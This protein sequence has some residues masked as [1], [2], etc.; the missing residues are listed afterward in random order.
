M[1]ITVNKSELLPIL[2]QCNSVAD[3]KSTMPILSNVLLHANGKLRCSATDLYQAVASD[4]AAKVK[5]K[6]TIALPARDLYERVKMLDGDI[7]ISTKGST[8]TIKSGSRVYKMHG[9]DGAEFPALPTASNDGSTLKVSA[10]SLLRLIV[11]TY[12]AV[13]SDDNRPGLNGALFEVQGD[14]MRMVAT[15]GRRLSL[16]EVP[17]PDNASNFSV[18]IPL[19]SLLELR[20]LCESV[21]DGDVTLTQEGPNLFATVGD[22]V[23]SA[24]LSEG[25]FPPY[26]QVIPSS[27][28]ANTT[29]IRSSLLAVVRAVSLASPDLSGGIKLTFGDGKIVAEAEDAASGEGRDELSAIH[30]GNSVTIGFGARYLLD[31]LGSLDTESVEISTGGDLDPIVIKPIGAIGSD[32]LALVMPMRT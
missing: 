10:A 14:K 31:A 6:G 26:Q 20:R 1:N 32:G 17:A 13:S 4:V 8:A 7:T 25:Q 27:S 11:G 24:K 2:A 29:V 16:T 12:L 28:T 9:I 23:F 19:K 22:V 21:D 18:L 5:E 30:E 15:D 3:K